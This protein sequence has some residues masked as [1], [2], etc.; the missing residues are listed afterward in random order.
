[1]QTITLEKLDCYLDGILHK[2]LYGNDISKNGIQ[3]QNSE[4]SCK[5]IKTIAV[6]TDCCLQTINMAVE[7]KA[8]LLFCHH[9]LFWGDCIP[10][11]NIH[12]TRIKTLLDNDIALYAS[13]IPLDANIEVGNNYGLARIIGIKD[14]AGFGVWRGMTIGVKGTLP[15]LQ[16]THEVARTL[17]DYLKCEPFMIKEFGKKSCKTVGIISGGTGSDI[18]QAVEAGLDLYI[19]GD[20]AHEQY[21][22]A[23]EHGINFIALGHYNSETVGVRLVK[24]KIENELGLKTF[25]LNAPTNL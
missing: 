23:K 11:T 22:F 12:Y 14:E 25:F 10:I 4:P 8:D 1:M 24:E 7:C 19:C 16:S 5:E 3:V 2:S 13:H 18:H 20:M 21:H 9:G 17:C 15:V 6:A